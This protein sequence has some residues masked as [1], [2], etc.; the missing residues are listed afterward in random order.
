MC[1]LAPWLLF[2]DSTYSRSME[3][4]IVAMR[5]LIV[6]KGDFRY[7]P[8]QFLAVLPPTCVSTCSADD[9]VL[10]A[11]RNAKSQ[12]TARH[13]QHFVEGV[14]G[15]S[16]AV[17]TAAEENQPLAIRAAQENH[18]PRAR[19]ARRQS[20]S[21]EHDGMHHF[22]DEFV[23]AGAVDAGD[24]S[25][26]SE[27]S[28]EMKGDHDIRIEDFD[29]PLMTESVDAA[30]RKASVPGKRGMCIV[31]PLGLQGSIC[32]LRILLYSSYAID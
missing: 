26:A 3:Q 9:A 22:D 12:A 31:A 17:D 30:A 16:A 14:S 11:R 8:G 5:E 13:E 29:M 23:D 27:M 18:I 24:D 10:V 2:L 15:P 4:S 7:W 1:L 19:V 25:D 21:A 28:K 32:S 6:L 20:D